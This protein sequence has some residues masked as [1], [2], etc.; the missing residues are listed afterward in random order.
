M[1]RPGEEL[2]SLDASVMTSPR[3]QP[4]LGDEA[5]MFLVSQIAG[6]LNE[7][8]ASLVENTTITVVNRAGFEHCIT[9]RVFHFRLS[10]P[11]LSLLLVGF[12]DS[13]LIL[14]EDSTLLSF[15]LFHAFVVCPGSLPV[16]LTSIAGL[17][18][19]QLHLTALGF[20][21]LSSWGGLS[22]VGTELPHVE[23]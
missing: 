3:V 6:S 9:A 19:L 13:F 1:A 10:E 16:S 8:L 15:E 23:A 11:F 12:H 21:S 4:F 14:C 17:L 22:L 2:D 5:V 18:A 20:L 7:A